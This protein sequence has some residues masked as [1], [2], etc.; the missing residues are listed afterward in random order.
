M[1]ITI[2]FNKDEINTLQTMNADNEYTE[3]LREVAIAM[4]NQI[5]ESNTSG[6]IKKVTLEG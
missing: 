6:S 5:M 1:K 3:A 2:D 4:V